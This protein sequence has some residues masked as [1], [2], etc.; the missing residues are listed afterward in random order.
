MKKYIKI[1]LIL[2]ITSAVQ[3]QN[4]NDAMRFSQNNLVGTAR[5]RALSGAFGAL[6][7][8]FSSLNINP[9]GS[10]IF[11]NNQVSMTFNTASLRN[12]SM[13]F[14]TSENENDS[15]FDIN[16]AGGVYVFKNTNKKSDWRKFSLALNYENLNNFDNSIFS[17]GTNTS[18]SG[19]EYFRYYAN[20]NGGETL[21]NLQLQTGE[22]ISDLYK[23]LGSNYGFS[24]QQA[25]LGYQGYIIEPALNYNQT[26]NRNYVSLVPSGGNYYQEN[27]IVSNGYNGKVSFNA[28]G[29]YKDNIF[30][31]VNLNSHFVDFTQR[32]SFYE[33]N[34]NNILSGVQRFRFDNDLTTFGNGISVQ[35]GTIAKVTK[36]LRL[37]L[38]YE[39]ATWF[40]MNDQL[41]QGLAVVSANALGELPIDYVNP[42]VI[43]IYEPY[44]LKTPAKWTG[45]LAYIFNK[46]GLISIDY[47]VKDYSKTQ[48]G[49]KDDFRNA[50]RDMTNL[51]GVSKEL[52]I[53]TEYRI[54]NL[55][56]RAGYKTEESPYKDGKTIGKITGISSGL[57]YD[58]G[59]T[60]LDLAYSRLER[61]G[62]I[63]FFNVGMMDQAVVKTIINNITLTLCFEL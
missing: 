51:L 28:A 32:T 40:E 61:N 62:S 19:G 9:A 55:S 31:G 5:F 11:S 50:N 30:F 13:Y 52:R 4:I 22:S 36:E 6:G 38:A 3:S 10:A 25:F 47:S 21:S 17:T 23:F 63:Q 8:D 41:T 56:L 45:S 12:N 24:S 20:S 7:G 1:L 34:S 54:K 53:G 46:T 59:G 49:P 43:N 60:K 27:S 2:I 15:S 16:Q 48:Y 57:G 58:F 39:S 37:G 14:G 42:R 18:T 33:E 29:Q 44:Q 35:L 26:S